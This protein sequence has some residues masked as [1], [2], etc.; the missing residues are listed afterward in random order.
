[1]ARA[2][3]YKEGYTKY[4]YSSNAYAYDLE[5]KHYYNEE[6]E[7]RRERAKRAKIQ[8][9]TEKHRAAAHKFK[10]TVAVIMVFA[11]CF[12]M[13]ASYAAVTQQRMKV[14]SLKDDLAYIKS[15][16]TSLQAEISDSVDLEYVKSEAIERL[17]MTEPQPYQV[18]YIDVPKQSY[19]VQ[20]ASAEIVE[21]DGF[22]FEAL[23]NL[24]NN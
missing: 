22:T 5:P 12:L 21:D 8:A 17:G 24:F 10:L 19:N 15:E 6:E 14:N 18:V 16:N 7:L 13:M 3:T 2:K 23:L 9:E 11:L 1:M 20:Y 4:N